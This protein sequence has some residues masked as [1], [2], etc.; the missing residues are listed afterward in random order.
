MAVIA[1]HQARSRRRQLL[2]QRELESKRK[3]DSEAEKN[4]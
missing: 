1:E 4:P 2:R 3:G